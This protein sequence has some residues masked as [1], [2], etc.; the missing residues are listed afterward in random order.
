MCFYHQAIL[1]IC[2]DRLNF[3]RDNVFLSPG[4]TVGICIDWVN[5][6]GSGATSFNRY[7]RLGICTLW[8]NFTMDNVFLVIF[9]I[10]RS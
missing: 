1:G 10:R 4:K 6:V 5:F 7:A 2:I 3:T 9:D 8:L